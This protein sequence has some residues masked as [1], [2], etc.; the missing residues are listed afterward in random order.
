M[1]HE[2]DPLAR[3]RASTPASD[4]HRERATR[5]LP[6][7][8]TRTTVF[9]EPYPV[10]M[11]SGRGCRVTDIDGNERVDFLNNYSSLILG[12]A[13]P[14]IVAAV[15]SQIARGSAF[16][17]PTQ[18]EVE[19]AERIQQRIASIEQL[20]FA[21]SGTEA[22]MF[23]MRI[24]RAAT[25]RSKI[26][27]FIGGYHGTHDLAVPLDTPG[28]VP[29]ISSLIV[30]LVYNDAQ[31]TERLIR[32]H[33]DSLACVIVEPALG[34]G[35]IVPAEPGFL[36]LLRRLADELGFI[37]IF[38][39]II[40]A[41]VAYGGAQELYGVRPDLTTLGKIIGGG[42]A[43]AAFGGR[44]DLMELLDPRRRGLFL[45]HGGTFNG[46]PVAAVAGRVTLD[47]LTRESIGELNR[48]GERACEE[49]REVFDRYGVPAQVTGIGSLFN[50]HWTSEPV[51]D[52]RTAQS[53]DNPTLER[54]VLELLNQGFILAPRGMG[55]IST[56]MSDD[57]VDGLADA[58]ARAVEVLDIAGSAERQQIAQ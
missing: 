4:R 32:E 58:V 34:A 11:E 36:E 12:H 7:G 23:A 22:T 50:I 49:L 8:T 53:G 28:T 18:A 21:N 39:E 48:L 57:E 30:P 43:L 56:P 26:G 3:Y 25:E 14:D 27:R 16:A 13:D 51:V 24:A 35:G 5:V 37:L 46:N 52:H 40:T 9:F 45:A 20:R 33:A 47:R 15:T 31:A 41:R 10:C 2:P 44:A 29:E 55:C 42:Y 19:L 54:L 38:D 1:T 6:G 17:A